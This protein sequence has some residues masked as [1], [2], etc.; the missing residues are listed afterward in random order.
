MFETKRPGE[1]VEARLSG[2]AS[3]DP[4]LNPVSVNRVSDHRM[5]KA[6]QMPPDLVPATRFRSNH[7]KGKTTARMPG[8][9]VWHFEAMKG[10]EVGHGGF[11]HL[12]VGVGGER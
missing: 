5:R 9:R 4:I 12:R 8:R 3:P 10:F 2:Q 11:Q 6:L 1:E 7:E